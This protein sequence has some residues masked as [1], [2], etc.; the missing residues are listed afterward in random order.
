MVDT[1]KPKCLLCGHE[2]DY[3][4]GK[5]GRPPELHKECRKIWNLIPWLE[6]ELSRIDF[7][8]TKKDE[9]RSTLWSLAN[10]MN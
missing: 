2:I 7:T 1:G 10:L 6:D 9:M 5:R 3:T 4:P 8:K